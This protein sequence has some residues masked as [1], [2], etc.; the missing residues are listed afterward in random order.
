[1][2]SIQR[3]KEKDLNGHKKKLKR[4]EA[5]VSQCDA[6]YIIF[7][8]KRRGSYGRSEPAMELMLRTPG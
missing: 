1:M 6:V 2:R 7:E 8:Q 4:A 5:E 3:E